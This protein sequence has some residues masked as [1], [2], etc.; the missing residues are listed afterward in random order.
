MNRFLKISACFVALVSMGFG[1]GGSS[2][3][4]PAKPLSILGLNPTEAAEK[5]QFMPGDAFEVK[6]S[7]LGLT[8]F[9]EK[10]MPSGEGNKLVT[11]TRFA[12]ANTADLRWVATTTHETLASQQAR[13]AYEADLKNNPRPIGTLAPPPPKTVLTTVSTSGTV[14]GINLKDTHA[15]FLPA[16]W[17]EKEV[18]LGGER[19]GVWLSDDAFQELSRTKQTTLSLGI[20]DDAANTIVK[21]VK[22]LQT[23][24]ATLRRQATQEQAKTDLTLLKSEDTFIEYPLTVN[25]QEIKVSAIKA[26]NWFGEIIVLN[27]RQNPMILSVVLNPLAAASDLKNL[28]G[29]EIGNVTIS[30]L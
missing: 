6:Q 30:R 23:A 15:A 27:N 24:L 13:A 12:P 3:G 8:G 9:W 2:T 28:F 11:V 29:Y 1:C 20:V 4:N 5:I 19:S 7:F 10:L 25:G 14:L 21:N 26:R 17:E 18:R 16:Y 22:E